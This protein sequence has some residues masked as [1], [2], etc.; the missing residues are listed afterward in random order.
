MSKDS[1][2][3]FGPIQSFLW[4]IHGY[5]L[6]K[7]IPMLILFG[8]VS[9]NYTVLR[10]AKDALVVNAPGSG[11]EAIPFLKF[12]GVLPGSVIFMLAYAQLSRF[13][14]K[15]SLFYASMA[16]FILFFAL[17]NWF[18]YPNHGWLHLNESADWLATVLPSGAKGLIANYRNWSFALFYIMAELWGSVTISLLFWGLA[19]DITRV[20]DAKRHYSLFGLAANVA[21]LS[22]G[23]SIIFAGRMNK[24]TNAADAW[25]SYLGTMLNIFVVLGFGAIAAYYYID[26]YVM[27]DARFKIDDGD[28][29]PKKKKAKSSL[30]DGFKELFNSSYLGYIAMLIICYNV[31]INLCEVTWKDQLRTW[32]RMASPEDPTSYYFASM[33][34]YSSTLGVVTLFM[35][36]FVGSNVIRRLGWLTGALITPITLLVTGLSFFIFVIFREPLSPLMAQYGLSPVFV[37]AILGGLQSLL[38]KAA[39]YSLFDPTKEMAYIPLDENAKV[40]GKAAIDVVGARFGKSGG[41]VIQQILLLM[42]V[43]LP[44][45]ASWLFVLLIVFGFFWIRSAILLGA[46]FEK[47]TNS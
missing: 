45:I 6:K 4:P 36:L 44:A 1:T 7:I 5:E 23:L 46:E 18:I 35:I 10:D 26:Q 11:A 37:A 41:G 24:A 32:S 15:A 28:K 2:S 38:A 20:T 43:T 21:L 40:K 17:F 22:S 34:M 29:K 8:C 9:F 25:S 16:P 42:F 33:G 31:M 47:K 19:N 3:E 12:W 39:K 30:M 13:L 14:S 27:S